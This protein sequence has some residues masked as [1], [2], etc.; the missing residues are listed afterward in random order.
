ME[1]DLQKIREAEH[2]N[3]D[4]WQFAALFV[5][6]I[7]TSTKVWT[8]FRSSAEANYLLNAASRP[9]SHSYSTGIS[10]RIFSS[11]Y[12][13]LPLKCHSARELDMEGKVL[14]FAM[15]LVVIEFSS[16]SFIGISTSSWFLTKRVLFLAEASK[17]SNGS[18]MV[19][20][21]VRCCLST[22]SERRDEATDRLSEN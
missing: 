2:R 20:M 4:V 12:R 15:L 17:T 11:S 10:V 9:G 16:R 19:R 13:L 14:C 5:D 6:I 3:N 1:A 22:W 18:H 8:N 7:I 21:V